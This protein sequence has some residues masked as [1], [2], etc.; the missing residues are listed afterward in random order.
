M[1]IDLAV[2]DWARRDKAVA[3]RLRR[4]DNR[5]IEYMRL[6]FSDFCPDEEEIE[7]RCRLVFSLWI[8]NYF[9]AADHGS[10][11]RSDVVTMALSRLLT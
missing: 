6:L 1:K 11:S 7:V 2:R 3:A 5:R 4:V 10:R 8:G 9:I